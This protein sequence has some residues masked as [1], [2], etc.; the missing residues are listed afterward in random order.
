MTPWI[1]ST[2]LFYEVDEQMRAMPNIPRPPLA[3][4]VVT[5][6]CSMRSKAWATAVLSL[7]DTRLS[8]VVSRLPERNPPLSPLQDPPRLTQVSWPLRPCWGSSTPMG[9]S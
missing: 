7:A 3:S 2:T 5:L 1:L 6:G 4:E 8:G 9:L